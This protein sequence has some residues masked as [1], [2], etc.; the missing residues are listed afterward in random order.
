MFFNFRTS[1]LIVRNVREGM[2][3]DEGEGTKVRTLYDLP[4]VINNL[5]GARGSVVG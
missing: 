2:R 4:Y 1:L 3:R 5:C